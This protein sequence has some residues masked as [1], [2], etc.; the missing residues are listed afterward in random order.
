MAGP[1]NGVNGNTGTGFGSTNQPIPQSVIDS[2]TGMTVT[3]ALIQIRSYMKQSTFQEF[4]VVQM[5]IESISQLKQIII[6]YNASLSETEDEN[7]DVIEFNPNVYKTFVE[8][9]D[10]SEVDRTVISSGL[11]ANGAGSLSAYF[12]SS[13][14]GKATASYV[15]MYAANPATDS[16]AQVQFAVGYAHIDG[17]GSLGNSTKTTAGNRETAAL[18]RQ[19]RNVILGPDS[20]YFQVADGST[21][22]LNRKD[23][24]FIVFNRAQ[25]R[26]KVDPGNWELHLSGSG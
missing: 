9:T 2:L 16:S 1:E 15:E 22:G 23:F 21:T 18:Y 14:A 6:S 17:S 24:I 5:G 7:G 19:F 8:E 26:E 10:I 11:F 4:F 20:T 13:T 12:S 25:M 3:N